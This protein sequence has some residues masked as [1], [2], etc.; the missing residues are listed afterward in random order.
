MPLAL[1]TV[2][3]LLLGSSP[4]AFAANDWE[5]EQ[6]IGRNKLPPRATFFRFDTA[7]QA[8]NATRENFG[9][10]DSPY[11]KLLNGDWKF[12]WVETPEE[13]PGEEFVAP[14][15]DD[16]GWETIPVPSNWQMHGYGRPIYLN[17]VY[18]FQ[19]NPP[20]VKGHHGNP[21]GSYR[22]AFTVP[23]EWEGRR[24]EINFDG[25]ESAFYLWCNGKKVGYSQGSRTPARF[26]LTPHL[27]QDGAE[28]VLAAQVFRWSDGSYLEDQDFWRLS[29]IFRD[30]YLESMPATHISDISVFTRT[31]TPPPN[32]WA[33]EC[34]IEVEEPQLP[35][36]VT[37]TLYDPSGNEVFSDNPDAS[38]AGVRY[39]LTDLMPWSAENPNLYRV[40]VELSDTDLQTTEA[41]VLDIG[42]RTSEIKD[43][44]LQVNGKYIYLNGV[45]RHEHHPYTG[46]T[47]SRESMIEDIRLMKQN[48]IN[49]V[50]TSH[51]PTCPE[52]Y[53]L[54]DRYGLYVIDEANVESH[55][56]GYGEASLAK[57]PAWEEAHLD[58]TRR[59]VERDKNHPSII[60]WSLGNEAGNGVNT[61]ATYDWIKERDKSRPV[62]YEQAH[63]KGRNTDIRAPMYATI[64]TM[65]QYAKGQMEGVAVDRPLIQCEYA[66][67]MGSSVGNLKEYWDAI[68]EHRAL[69]G[70]FIWDWVDQGLVKKTEDGT[71][72]WAYGGDF[73]DEPN[74]GNFC[75][76]GLVQPDRKPNPH[77]HEVKKVYQRIETEHDTD[78]PGKLTIT[79]GFDH[80][81]LEAFELAWRIEVDG[82][83]LKRGVAKLPEVAAGD[84]TE[85]SLPITAPPALPGQEAV[86][87][88]SYRLK[89]ETLW[90]PAGH[91]V[92]WEQFVIEPRG[93]VAGAPSTEN[94]LIFD[95]QKDNLTLRTQDVVVEIDSKTG[96]LRRFTKDG[97]DLVTEPIVPCY[98]RVPT[99]NDRGNRMPK[100]LGAWKNV[101]EGR[102]LIEI[103]PDNNAESFGLVAGF[104][105]LDGKLKET[106]A[107]RLHESGDLTIRHEIEA[108]EALPNLPRIGLVTEVP[109][110]LSTATWYGRG[111]HETMWDRK[112]GAAIGRY[113]MPSDSLI[114]QYCRPQENGQRS[115]VRWLA[116]T[117]DT[118]RGL[119]IVGDPSFQF[120]VRPY[121][122]SQ[123]E[124][125]T[126]PHEIEACENLTLHLDHQQMGVG[127]DN[128]WGART[129]PEYRLPAGKYAYTLTLRPY[130]AGMGPV[131]V[132]ARRQP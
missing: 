77:L 72:F 62:Q 46:H 66:H 83:V 101:S 63:F 42:F 126:H 70:G 120:T 93:V 50:R 105:S 119:L 85:V 29:G 115:D 44:V 87:T 61:E 97:E 20:L 59:M 118:D 12:H 48:N 90:A 35:S 9:R 88:V 131:G 78:T 127:G 122:D 69:Q 106:L 26:D 34:K 10:A 21:V 5:D 33:F 99:D 11:V 55:G 14:G 84:S 64:D 54:C 95:T 13:R 74:A 71:E 80:R 132:V 65:V 25:V 114:H 60:I 108:D 16:S 100:R 53:S 23:A 86:L 8:L 121:S 57:D 39:H 18:P 7:E 37:I 104:E 91:E 47:I 31:R 19:K 41:T 107:Y 98:W 67:A 130:H 22:K 32:H 125:A 45:N 76:N 102:S 92:V 36:I 52:F 58:R 15:F 116:L 49:A 111:P 43:G 4:S 110:S 24:V 40:V 51:Y 6:V 79:N 112:S 89:A 113:S 2:L 38:D 28:N 75:C 17:E 27:N 129:H 56:M 73:G 81:S 117:S 30:V 3:A 128:S 1:L 94:P 68:R 109:K 124:A 82:E 123:L 96:M 103:D